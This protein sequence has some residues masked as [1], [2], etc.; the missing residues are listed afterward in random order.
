VLNGGGT[1]TLTIT[2][3]AP[4]TTTSQVHRGWT[5]LTGGAALAFVV[6]L[7]VPRRRRWGRSVW[8]IAVAAVLTINLVGCTVETTSSTPPVKQLDGGSPLGTVMFNIV[9]AG[10]DGVSSIRHNYQYQVTIQ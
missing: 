3:T 1:T 9:T 6:A 8:V 5:G 2:T 10:S 4:Q 7:F